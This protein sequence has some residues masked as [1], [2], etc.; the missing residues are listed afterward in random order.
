MDQWL[1]P[2]FPIISNVKCLIARA[3]V[4]AV[5]TISPAHSS[6]VLW[7]HW[8]YLPSP[9]HHNPPHSVVQ[10]TSSH[11]DSYSVS[12]EFTY[13]KYYEHAATVTEICIFCILCWT[14]TDG[15]KN[16]ISVCS[17]EYLFLVL[18][19]VALISTLYPYPDWKWFWAIITPVCKLTSS[20]YPELN[21]IS[22]LTMSGICGL[23]MT[24]LTADYS[25]LENLIRKS[26][27][28]N[29][30]MRGH[31]KVR[32]WADPEQ[33]TPLYGESLHTPCLASPQPQMSY[34]RAGPP[35]PSLIHMVELEF[36]GLWN[37]PRRIFAQLQKLGVKLA[38][39]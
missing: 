27:E 9:E 5:S 25:L 34:P 33:T 12:Q 18:F 28:L 15:I 20:H 32:S 22:N 3:L 7:L 11:I 8:L 6:I 24:L 37:N 13:Q 36:V 35:T 19:Q 17:N 38:R 31:I 14:H 29:V 1:S 39:T 10:L 16:I 30:F 2:H 23:M 21:W 4:S 26:Y